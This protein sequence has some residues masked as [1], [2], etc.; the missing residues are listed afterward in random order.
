MRPKD[1][2]GIRFATSFS[3]HAES[4]AFGFTICVM[5]VVSC[6]VL[7]LMCVPSRGVLNPSHEHIYQKTLYMSNKTLTFKKWGW[8]AILYLFH[9]ASWMSH[10]PKASTAPSCARL[11]K[12]SWFQAKLACQACWGSCAAQASASPPA[13]A[14]PCSRMLPSSQ[15]NHWPD[16]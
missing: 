16:P 10:H 4:S 14:V 8:L 15:T 1:M 3:A 7:C 5:F 13:S 9:T 12:P 2:F 6:C 11:S